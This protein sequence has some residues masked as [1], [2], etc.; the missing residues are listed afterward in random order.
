[1]LNYDTHS[2]LININNCSPAKRAS[3]TTTHMKKTFIYF[4]LFALTAVITSCAEKADNEL[5]GEWEQVVEQQGIKAVS[6]YDFK[7][8]GEM[9]QTLEMTSSSPAVN[10][11][12]DGTCQYTYENNT[13][14]FKFS[15]EDFNFSTFEME[16]MPDYLIEASMEQ[17][18]AQMTDVEQSFTDVK[19]DGDVLTANFNGQQVTLTRK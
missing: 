1:M 4:F 18:K 13:I 15:A 8:G 10:I 19:I 6:V 3:K 14:T 5:V 17:M 12:A 9:Y 7:N 11:V 2:Y 16:G